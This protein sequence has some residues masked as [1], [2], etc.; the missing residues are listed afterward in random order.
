MSDQPARLQIEELD[1]ESGRIRNIEI[2]YGQAEVRV[3]RDRGCDLVLESPSAS[4]RHCLLQQKADGW[5]VVD[6]QS[7]LGTF[8]NGTRLTPDAPQ[9]LA[10][11]DTINCSTHQL[12]VH[13]VPLTDPTLRPDPHALS[14]LMEGWEKEENSPPRVWIFPG[15]G[16]AAPIGGS[17]SSGTPASF[18]MTEEGA[19]LTVGRSAE[20]D[21]RLD[22]PFRVV[23]A[24]HAR[25]ERNWAGTFLF[26]SSING[27][28]V[29]GTRVEGQTQIK[30]GDRITIASADEDA[31]RPLLVF[32]DAGNDASPEP[33][34]G[35]AGVS[36]ASGQAGVSSGPAGGT[37]PVAGSAV[38]GGASGPESAA[39]SPRADSFGPSPRGAA[40]G[41][42]AGT[43]GSANPGGRDSAGVS[44]E[45]GDGLGPMA[46]SVGDGAQHARRDPDGVAG[47]PDGATLSVGETPASVETGQG[48]PPI[49]WLLISV[50]VVSVLALAT[51]LVWG[52]ILLRD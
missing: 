11:G 29:N 51:V 6:L 18:P 30:D 43:A 8:H 35:V 2:D 49:N 4:R 3:G 46:R 38:P 44:P 48:R 26:D 39:R 37:G 23:S 32:A 36:G 45:D 27:I 40:G 16:G 25:F 19:V 21:I 7:S 22:D 24:V 41:T 9:K 31:E 17:D 15:G 12:R 1:E 42:G 20:C 34:R 28:Y 33:Q 50:V 13:F 47:K 10:H 5:Y 52:L 14:R